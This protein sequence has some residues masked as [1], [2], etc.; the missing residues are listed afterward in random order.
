[1][2]HVGS[3]SQVERVIGAYIGCLDAHVDDFRGTS[4]LRLAGR[5]DIGQLAAHV[6]DEIVALQDLLPGAEVYQDDA[7]TLAS[8]PMDAAYR[9][10]H[11]ATHAV[12]RKDNPLFSGLQLSD[13]WL[14]AH[15]LYRRRLECSLATLSACR[16]GMSAVV[17]GDELL[18]LVR[19]FLS[20]GARAVMVSLWAAHDA[21]TAELMQR[22]YSRLADGLSRAAALRAAQQSLR[23]DYL[24]P[25]YW[26]AFALVGAR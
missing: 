11:F 17:P 21:A 24:H 7:A 3:D 8:V 2:L 5:S 10:I 1:M 23:E 13:G 16:T 4:N 22:F 19:G 6:E 20:A 18:G 26:A 9:Y 14:I 15:D 25:Y 12:F